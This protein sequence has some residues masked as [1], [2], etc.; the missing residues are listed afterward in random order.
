[1][2]HD[3][4]TEGMAAGGAVVPGRLVRLAPEPVRVAIPGHGA[5]AEPQVEII[6]EGDVIQAIDVVCTCGRRIR[7][8]C[9]Y[10]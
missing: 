3:E 1:M 2:E 6:R 10:Q 8:R 7:L 9:L 4:G 5:H